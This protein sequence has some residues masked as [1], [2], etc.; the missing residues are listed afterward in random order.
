M[1]HKMKDQHAPVCVKAAYG[2]IGFAA[3]K[4]AYEYLQ[5]WTTPLRKLPGPKRKSFMQ[6]NFLELVRSSMWSGIA[7]IK[8]ATGT[9]PPM[10][11][12]ST[13]FGRWSVLVLNR[14]IVK[15][16]IT[17]HASKKPLRFEKNC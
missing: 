2:D 17:P 9:V 10:I 5:F 14:D 6:G 13:L 4:I 15:D 12:C 16:I 8:E 7:Q 3:L 1:A 11:S